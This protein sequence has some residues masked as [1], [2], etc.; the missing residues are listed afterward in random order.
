[1]RTT[2]EIIAFTV[3]LLVRFSTEKPEDYMQEIF[4]K[5]D[6]ILAK[7]CMKIPEQGLFGFLYWLDN[8][9]IEE[10]EAL[11]RYIDKRNK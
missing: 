2:L 3:E 1:M 10:R 4:G 6:P 5:Q 9:T 11:V 8:L 7:K